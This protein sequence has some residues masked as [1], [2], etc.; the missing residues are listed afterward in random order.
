MSSYILNFIV[1]PPP[2][3][4]IYPV[5]RRDAR[6]NCSNFDSGWPVQRFEK[7][8]GGEGEK[9]LPKNVTFDFERKIGTGIIANNTRVSVNVRV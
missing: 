3:P 4:N 8:K 6:K 9:F 1:A 5:K 7:K 2:P